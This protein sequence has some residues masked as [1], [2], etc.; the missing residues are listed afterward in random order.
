MIKTD[1]HRAGH[2]QEVSAWR[3][4]DTL[5]YRA[6]ESC[7]ATLSGRRSS[8]LPSHHPSLLVEMPLH[9]EGHLVKNSVATS[10]NPRA[11]SK[12]AASIFFFQAASWTVQTSFSDPGLCESEA[13]C[14]ENYRV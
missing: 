6:S 14:R 4:Q 12:S 9:Y 2:V 7:T 8:A 1:T 11:S 13:C 5:Q 3:K 10:R